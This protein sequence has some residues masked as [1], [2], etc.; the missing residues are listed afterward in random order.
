[1]KY[2]KVYIIVYLILALLF[3]IVIALDVLNG[4]S[5]FQFYSDT[6][7]WIDEAVYGGH[8]DDLTMINRNELGPVTIL[9][10]LGP[11]N[12]WAMFLFNIIVF[13]VS[14]YF[15]SKNKNDVNLRRLFLLIMV[16]PITFTSLLSANKEIFAL[17]CTCLI[18]YN[19]NRRS[20]FMVVVIMVL[21][22]MA[23][24]QYTLFYVVYL[25]M[26]SKYNFIKSR[27][28][29]L[30][31]LL[32]GSTI[33]LLL[34]QST[35]LGDVFL[36]YTFER[37]MFGDNYEGAGTFLTLLEIQSKYGYIVVFIPKILIILIARIKMYG[38]FFDFS[39]AYNNVILFLQTILHIYIIVKCYVKKVYKMENTFFYVALIYFVI[40]GM[41]PIFNP[42][43]FYPAIVFICYELSLKKN[44]VIKGE[45]KNP[46]SG[47][48]NKMTF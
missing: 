28:L 45:I 46:Q 37:E 3:F 47:Y 1:M 2:Y 26:F 44:S 19:H 21:S 40:F 33:G 13:L 42:R 20:M 41:T 10:F 5:D 36:K 34:F 27:L 16:S 35:L 48:P 14:L 17:I 30:F 25:F 11:H 18:I 39:D 22:Y 7:T 29:F 43:Y 4:K 12:Y 32:S 31:L 8:G 38:S 24:W 23:R 9:R 15:L 6:E